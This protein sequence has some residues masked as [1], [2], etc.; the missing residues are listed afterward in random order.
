MKPLLCWRCKREVLMLDE[1]EFWRVYRLFN[2]G[3]G[4]ARE[5]LYG[6]MSREYERITGAPMRYGREPFHHRLAL[7]GPPC[8]N[9]SKPLRSPQAKLCGTC[10]APVTGNDAASPSDVP[11]G[12]GGEEK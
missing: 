10:M 4:N 9:C 1:E 7:F 5:R 6:P 8:T 11:R 12:T 3:M 2:T